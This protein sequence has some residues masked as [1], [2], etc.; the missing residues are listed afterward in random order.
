[1]AIKNHKIIQYVPLFGIFLHNYALAKHYA[2]AA[3]HN[4]CMTFDAQSLSHVITNI[5]ALHWCFMCCTIST[6]ILLYKRTYKNSPNELYNMFSQCLMPPV[7]N[8]FQLQTTTDC[9]ACYWL[10]NGHWTSIELF[11]R[12]VDYSISE[13]SYSM[14]RLL[15]ASGQIV[16]GCKHAGLKFKHAARTE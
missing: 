8:N 15:R 7:C 2:H 4:A 6:I 3:L 12:S 5:Y 13:Q 11:C 14:V 1:L 9:S 10:M 16:G